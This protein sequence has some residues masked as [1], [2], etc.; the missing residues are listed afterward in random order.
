ME[1]TKFG[2]Y[3]LDTWVLANVSL[4]V[5]GVQVSL[6]EAEVE[7]SAEA[8]EAEAQEADTV[9]ENKNKSSR[10]RQSDCGN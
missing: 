10:W 6:V 9:N 4:A 5:Q 2:Y 1:I 8:Q 7:A 3:W